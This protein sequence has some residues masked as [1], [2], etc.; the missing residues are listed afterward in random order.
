MRGR[1]CQSANTPCSS[2]CTRASVLASAYPDRLCLGV[3]EVDTGALSCWTSTLGI[4]RRLARGLP[5]WLPARL[6][7][8]LLTRDVSLHEVCVAVCV[9]VCVVCVCDCVCVRVCVT[10]CVCAHTQCHRGV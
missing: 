10:V 9:A 1:G 2:E 6:P 4:T 8:R 7:A 3:A 5:G